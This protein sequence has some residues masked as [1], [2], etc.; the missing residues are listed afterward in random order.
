M[1]QPL[2]KGFA[3]GRTIFAQ[4]ARERLADPIRGDDAAV[5][6]FCQNVQAEACD[7]PESFFVPRVW[8]IRRPEPGPMELADVARMI[9][10]ASRA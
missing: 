1:H 3:V 5:L 7:Y 4:A 8:C 9:A 10:A 2:L 6:A